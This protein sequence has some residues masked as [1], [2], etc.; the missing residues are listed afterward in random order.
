MSTETLKADQR[1]LNQSKS[2]LNLKRKTGTIPG[3]IFGR[4]LDKSIPISVDLLSFQKVYAH[5]GKIFQLNVGGTTHLINAKVIQ[6]HPVTHKILHVEFHKLKAGEATTVA[7]TLHITGTAPGVKAGGVVSLL[8]ETLS[9]TADPQKIPEHIDIDVS[10]LELEETI[11]AGDI[12]LPAGVTLDDEPTETIVSCRAP[13]VVEED[14]AEDAAEAEA[15]AA[16]EK[17]EAKKEEE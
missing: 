8:H 14:A 9:V 4:D 12:K 6:R 13:K 7:V 11:K 15:E 17:K 1:D 2:V 10:A 3:N 5:S 16:P